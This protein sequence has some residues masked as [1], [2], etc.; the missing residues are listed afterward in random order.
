MDRISVIIHYAGSGFVGVYFNP[1]IKLFFFP[2][3]SSILISSLSSLTSFFFL[4]YFFLSVSFLIPFHEK[5]S[6]TCGICNA[7]T[8]F[9]NRLHLAIIRS[10]SLTTSC[11]GCTYLYKLSQIRGGQSLS[12][13]VMGMYTV[14]LL[15]VTIKE[16][17]TLFPPCGERKRSRIVWRGR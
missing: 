3:S 8:L 15:M 5:P 10:I 9:S 17:R 6:S 1:T 14:S 4:W 12:L 7:N 2:P 13:S 16:A 11:C